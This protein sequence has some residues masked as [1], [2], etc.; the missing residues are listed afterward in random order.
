M[1]VRFR[2]YSYL[3]L[4]FETAGMVLSMKSS[5]VPWNTLEQAN[6]KLESFQK[7]KASQLWNSPYC[8]LPSN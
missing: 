1:R 2:F 3:I 7:M 6:C 5:S 4:K 8:R